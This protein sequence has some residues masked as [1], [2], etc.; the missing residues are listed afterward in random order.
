MNDFH[1]CAD[2]TSTRE[3]EPLMSHNRLLKCLIFHRGEGHNF[4][5]G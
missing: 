2:G 5:G 1:S 4:D 3:F